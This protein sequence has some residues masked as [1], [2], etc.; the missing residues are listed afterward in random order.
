MAFAAISLVGEGSSSSGETDLQ[1][2]ARKAQGYLLRVEARRLQQ[3]MESQAEQVEGIQLTDSECGT[4]GGGGSKAK[5]FLSLYLLGNLRSFS[6][7]L[8]SLRRLDCVLGDER[9]LIAIA[10][11]PQR[12]QH[13][14]VG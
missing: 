7:T 11:G 8:N 9:E 2:K 12:V 10:S 1:A 6:S 14:S 3:R 13:R 4:N 5:K